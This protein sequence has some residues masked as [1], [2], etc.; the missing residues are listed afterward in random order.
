MVR[1]PR[2]PIIGAITTPYYFSDVIKRADRNIW[3]EAMEKEINMLEQMK[4]FELVTWDDIPKNVQLLPSR[5]VFAT[6]RDGRRKARL[7]AGGHMQHLL[8]LMVRTDR[9]L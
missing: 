8:C 2:P 1:F 6:K 5:F 7:V 9:R 4:T 3:E